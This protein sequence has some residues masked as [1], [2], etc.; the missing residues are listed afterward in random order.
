MTDYEYYVNFC[1]KFKIS[2]K[3]FSTHQLQTFQNIST[4]QRLGSTATPNFTIRIST[5]HLQQY[6]EQFTVREQLVCAENKDAGAA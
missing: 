5:L 2:K 4:L 6:R 3:K 1:K